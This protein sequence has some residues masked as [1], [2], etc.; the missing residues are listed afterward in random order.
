LREHDRALL[1]S[2]IREAGA[3]ARQYFEA[4]AKAWSKAKGD[5]ITEADLAVDAL[6]KRRIAA[7]RPQDGWLSEETRD[8]P[9]RLARRR[10]WIVDPIDGTIAFIK[11][12]PHFT[13]SIALVEDGAPI[14]GAVF[15][16]VLDELF[17][18]GAGEG[19][20]LNDASIRV[21]DRAALEGCRMLAPRDV[22]AHPDWPEPWPPMEIENRNSIAYR[23]ALV[24]AGRFD[25]MMVLS[26]KREWDVAAGDLILREAGGHLTTHTGA[27]LRYNQPDP[28]VPSLVG[29]A[30]ILHEAIIGKVQALSLR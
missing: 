4:G 9:A 7:A 16:P 23:L 19:A 2:T 22:L 26:R 14:L 27:D 13:V 17:E 5:P 12:R 3:L 8:D 18:A 10:V 30:P 20:R 6:I 29:A 28:F 11:K 24:A 21:G 15:N 1:L 25:A